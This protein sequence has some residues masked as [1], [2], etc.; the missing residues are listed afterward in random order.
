MKIIHGKCAEYL[1]TWKYNAL[2]N[3]EKQKLQICLL[4]RE[5]KAI[6]LFCSSPILKE[7][8]TLQ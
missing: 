6:S 5:R 3:S 2:V 1:C 7:S 4:V 8:N